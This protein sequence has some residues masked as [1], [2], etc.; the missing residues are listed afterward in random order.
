LHY[1]VNDKN[2]NAAT[3]EF[4][5]GKL[6]PHTGDKLPIPT[7]TND[8]YERS[9]EFSK[10]AGAAKALG[11]GSLERFAR[12]AEKTKEFDKTAQKRKRSR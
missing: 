6:V 12:A 4:L 5:N 3:I 2:G 1:L 7:L 10:K 8:T 11:P 9:L